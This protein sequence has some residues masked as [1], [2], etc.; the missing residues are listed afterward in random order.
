MGSLADRLAWWGGC[1]TFQRMEQCVARGCGWS[2]GDGFDGEGLAA[3]QVTLVLLRGLCQVLANQ[4]EMVGGVVAG[5]L[6]GDRLEEASVCG[7]DIVT[8]RPEGLA[9]PVLPPCELVSKLLALAEVLE[10]IFQ[11]KRHDGCGYLGSPGFGEIGD[12]HIEVSQDQRRCGGVFES[13][14]GCLQVREV[15]EMAGG[16]VNADQWSVFVP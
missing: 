4:H 10:H 6:H 2:D 7:Q 14:Q 8:A 13:G 16:Q 3:V 11:A 12:V 5:V 1:L 15:V 9:V